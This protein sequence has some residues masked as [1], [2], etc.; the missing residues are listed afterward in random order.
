MKIIKYN[1]SRNVI[2]EFQDSYKIK[3]K[4][5]YG[6]FKN[7]NVRNP[8]NKTIY[9]KKHPT[10]NS[11][12]VCKEWHNY[13]VFGDW[14]DKNYYKIEN[15]NMQLD[16]DILFKGNKIY[17]YKTTL[18]VPDNINTLF[19]KNNANRGDY[20]IGVCYNKNDKVYTSECRIT[21]F[22]N[23]KNLRNHLGRFNDPI[24]AFNAY[25]IYKEQHIKDV[26]DHYKSQIPIK[27]YDALYAY[28][29]E[30]TD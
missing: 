10:Y 30:I 13:Q 2:I 6:D 3:I 16:K 17:N 14:F 20:P 21:S 24:S 12:E 29:V 8:Y 26:A 1:N 11:V 18:F 19:V 5:A 15:E 22:E 4:V 7:G 28:E 27:L 25:K 23:N 9:N